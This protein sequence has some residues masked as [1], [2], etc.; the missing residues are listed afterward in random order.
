MIETVTYCSSL[1]GRGKGW[2][3]CRG[4]GGKGRRWY[5]KWMVGVSVLIEM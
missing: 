1:V 3:G 5:W 2:L 4:G